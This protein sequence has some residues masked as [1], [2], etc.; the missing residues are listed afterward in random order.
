MVLHKPLIVDGVCFN[1]VG[2]SE[3]W[4][5]AHWGKEVRFDGVYFTNIVFDALRIIPEAVSPTRLHLPIGED[6]TL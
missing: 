4:G 3:G 5:L 1:L 2:A 6:L